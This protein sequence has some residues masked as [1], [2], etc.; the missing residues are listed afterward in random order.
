MD[1]LTANT[2]SLLDSNHKDGKYISA[3]DKN[4]I[5][6]GGGDTGTDCI[7]TSLRHGC[8]SLVNFELFPKPPSER[9]SNNP[10]PTFRIFKSDYGRGN[11]QDYLETIPVFIR[12]VLLALLG[13]QLE[14]LSVFALLM[15]S[16]RKVSR[17]I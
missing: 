15:L 8:K 16:W 7:G 9:A 6:I 14:I 2:K 11:Q 3:K 13:I 10:W 4:V 5:V 17:L 12:T 1:F